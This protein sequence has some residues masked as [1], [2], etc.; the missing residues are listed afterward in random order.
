MYQG[1][2]WL[3]MV[4]AV[5]LVSSQLV[6]A[7]EVAPPAIHQAPPRQVFSAFNLKYIE[8]D[9]LVKKLDDYT[10]I[11]LRPSFSYDVLHIKGAH[12][13][14]FSTTQNEFVSEVKKLVQETKKP[15]VFYCNF[16]LCVMAFKAAVYM[17][18]A[19]MSNVLVFDTGIMPMAKEHPTDCVLEGKPMK[20]ASQMITKAEFD[21]HLLSPD[22]IMGLVN[23]DPNAAI[24]DIREKWQRAGISWF[25]MRDVNIPYS[26]APALQSSILKAKDQ[27]RTLYF[28]DV[29]GKQVI[30]LQYWLKSHD[31]KNYWFVKGGAAAMINSLQS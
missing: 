3:L 11:D 2:I 30:W 10:I 9:D 21:S 22:K 14:S 16:K 12:S 19:G 25:Q 7:A 17:K 29:K 23:S 24:I 1:R 4:S 6:L 15:V 5:M 31:V 13:I 26:D 28:L 27:G 8:M 18:N 20:S